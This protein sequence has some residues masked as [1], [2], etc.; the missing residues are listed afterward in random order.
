M[1]REEKFSF[2]ITSELGGCASE[3]LCGHYISHVKESAERSQEKA[4]RTEGWRKGTAL[5]SSLEH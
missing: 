1:I 5:A 3:A 2:S 4:N